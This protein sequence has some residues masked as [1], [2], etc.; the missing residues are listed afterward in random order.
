MNALLL[1]HVLSNPEAYTKEPITVSGWV[2][3]VRDSKSFGFIELNDGTNFS[4]LQIVFERD[5]LSNYDEIA[6]LGTGSAIT[7][8]GMLILTPQAKQPCELKA[9]EIRIEGTV[10]PDYPLQK[11]RHTVEFLRTIPHLRQRTNLLSAVFRVR[12]LAAFA[13]H[14]FFNEHNFVYVTTPILTGSDCEGAGEMF[15]VTTLDLNNVP[16]KE[17]DSVD[18]SQDFFQKPVSLTVSGQL[19]GESY[20][21]AFRNIYTF[22]PTF[23]AEKSFTG[24]HAAEFWMIE[25]EMAFADLNDDMAV[26][27]AM[28]KSVVSYVMEQAPEEMEFFNKFV[29]P[30]LLDRLTNLVNS[31]FKHITY[32]QAIDILQKSGKKFDN[33]VEWGCDL[34]TEHERYITEEVYGC[35]V[36][37]TDYPMDIKAFYM[38][39]NPD[40]KT[41]AAMD[42]LVPGVGEIIGGSEREADYEKLLQR[43]EQLHMDIETYKWYLDLRRFGS[44]YHSGFGLGFERLLM[45][46]TGISN[47]R[48]VLPFPRTTGQ[49]DM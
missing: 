11:K 49:C 6:H 47:I 22:G 43:M 2:K 44:I 48:D 36:F 26:A 37:V 45:Y 9:S 12:S 17:D 38:K 7:A 46:I 41:V 4:N 42:L 1:K 16:K 40:G 30:T 34:Q 33:K 19:M 35:P 29:E 3:T 21:L 28:I 20:A 25:P 32:T 10:A 13:I 5:K 23:R 24:R 31:D 8:T 18:Y 39:Q 15:Q 14:K 27:Q